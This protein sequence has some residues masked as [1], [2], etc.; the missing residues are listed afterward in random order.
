MKSIVIALMLTFYASLLFAEQMPTTWLQN[1]SSLT[2]AIENAQKEDKKGIFI[3]ITAEKCALCNYMQTVIFPQAQIANF[4]Q[5]NFINLQINASVTTSIINF[6]NQASTTTTVAKQLNSE[7]KAY[8]LALF[9]NPQGTL[10]YSFSGITQNPEEFLWLGEYILQEHY[11]QQSF[12]D[13][14][15]ARYVNQP[16]KTGNSQAFFDVTF[17]DLQAE[18]QTAKENGKQ[19]IMLFF[20]MEGCPFCKRM[21]DTVFTQPDVQQFYKERFLIFPIDILGDVELTDFEG[22]TI[23]SKVFSQT[24]N[25]VRSTPV[26]IFYNLAG[27]PLY[28]FTGMTEDAQSFIWLAEYVLS[29]EYQRQLFKTYQ[30]AKRNP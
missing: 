11:Q 2:Q 28:R 23:S 6:E 9:F 4:Y 29:G 21:R 7:G 22:N 3:F 17:G 24:I 5:Q 10:L 8:P 13:Y 25:R 27:E 12:T 30:Q 19:G 18:L 14:K 1:P 20:E 26:I 15:Q 16:T